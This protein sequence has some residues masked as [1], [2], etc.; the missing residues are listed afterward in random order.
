MLNDAAGAI[1]QL[2]GIDL[3]VDHQVAVGLA[4]EDHRRRGQHVEDELGGG[5]GLETRR[6]GNHLRA[7]RRR[8]GQVDE[9]LQLRARDRRSRR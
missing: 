1:A 5:A 7:H 3:H 2:V 9:C 6:A 8:D 4:G